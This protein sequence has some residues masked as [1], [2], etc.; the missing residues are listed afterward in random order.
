MDGIKAGSVGLPI[1]LKDY[2]ELVDWTGRVFHAGKTG[3]IP[4][5]LQSIIQ[6]L[7]LKPESWL[8]QQKHFG[9]RYFLAAGAKEKI[10][11][12]AQNIGMKW[13]NGQGTSSPYIHIH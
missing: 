4:R 2:L 5:N 3:A 12:L 6:R 9:K 1:Q 11:V 7:K 13:M 8:A 10:R